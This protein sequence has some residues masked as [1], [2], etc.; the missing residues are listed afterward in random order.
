ML[1]TLKKLIT[2]LF[3]P[4]S[5]SILV[6]TA[7]AVLIWR[8]K[9]ERIGRW[10][11]V[12]SALVL[13]V[14]SNKGVAVLLLSPLELR[15]SAIREAHSTDELPAE[16]QACHAVVVLGGG[17]ADSPSLSRVNQLS[18]AALG[19]TAEAIR[20]WRLL[21]NASYI[22]SGHHIN[23][24][25]HAQ[26]LGEAAMSLG[27]PAGRIVRLDEPRDTEDEINELARRYGHVP[28]AIVTSAWHMPR[29]ME[30][31]QNVGLQ[32]VPCPSD[33]MLRPDAD[34]GSG[35]L[36]WDIGALERSTKAVHEYLGLLWLKLR[37]K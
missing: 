3:L 37:G 15:Y 11:L 10:L 26:V 24:L 8:K 30:L 35:L 28:I 16:L 12:A 25:S 2:L 18:T 27:V 7:G 34:Q 32:V 5:F 31:S 4:L 19:R 13:L 21:P 1:F 22:V 29:V 23:G 17:H 33:Y 20:I 36:S 14:F 6:G 9:T